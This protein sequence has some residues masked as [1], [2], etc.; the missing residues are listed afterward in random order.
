MGGGVFWA[1]Y[2]AAEGEI[3][4]CVLS[5]LLLSLLGFICATEYRRPLSTYVY[6]Y[7]YLY[8]V[9]CHSYLAN[10]ICW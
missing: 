4:T 1:I 2:K 3:G 10:G 6:M 8:R 7:P 9:S 5:N